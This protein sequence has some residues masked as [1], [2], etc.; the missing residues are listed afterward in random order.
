MNKNK[1]KACPFCGSDD[2]Q[3][4]E[5]CPT[6]FTEIYCANCGVSLTRSHEAEVINAWNK[7]Y[8]P[9]TKHKQELIDA[10]LLYPEM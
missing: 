4:E 1:L 2:V 8:K 5:D 6:G 7:R 3:I 9:T 10:G